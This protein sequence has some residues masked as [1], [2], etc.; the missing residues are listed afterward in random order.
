MVENSVAVIGLIGDEVVGG[1]A[2][3]QWQGIGGVIGLPAG[4]EEADRPAEAVDRD[5]PFAGQPSSGA[6]QSLVLDPPFWPVAAWA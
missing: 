3:D 6:P 2:G 4:E 1:E 5:V